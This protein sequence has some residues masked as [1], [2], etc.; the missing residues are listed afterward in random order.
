MC[1]S[2]YGNSEALLEIRAEKYEFAGFFAN[3]IANN[4]PVINGEITTKDQSIDFH[5]LVIEHKGQTPTDEQKKMKSAKIYLLGN[6]IP[7]STSTGHAILSSTAKELAEQ[8]LVEFSQLNIIDP[9]YNA[10]GNRDYWS[11]ILDNNDFTITNFQKWLNENTD[12]FAKTIGED[13][14][15]IAFWRWAK[16]NLSDSAIAN[17]PELPI[18]LKDN[19][20]TTVSDV[21]YLADCYVEKAVLKGMLRSL[22]TMQTLFHLITC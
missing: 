22:T 9:E 19:T 10:E 12:I 6:T 7:S 8:G 11:N 20:T 14:K 15:N 3:V 1:S 17:L 21:I 4:I 13:T 18:L 2:K 5:N 16:K